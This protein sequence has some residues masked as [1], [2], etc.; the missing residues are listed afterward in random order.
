MAKVDPFNNFISMVKSIAS[1]TY[2]TGILPVYNRM[3]FI[4]HTEINNN[5]N[6]II[7]DMNT[8]RFRLSV[9]FLSSCQPRSRENPNGLINYK[10]VFLASEEIISRILL[11]DSNGKHY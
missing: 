3:T 4:I 10:K 7:N 2:Y 9:F 11:I 5:S 1:D 6:T 8:K